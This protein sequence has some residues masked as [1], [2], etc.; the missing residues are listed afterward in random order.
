M[1]NIIAIAMG[2]GIGSLCRY[3]ITVGAEKI[4]PIYPLG[5]LVANLVGSLIIGIFWCYFD[6]I[7]ISHQFRLF[8]FTGFLGGF[9][10]F[11]TFSRECVQFF[12]AGEPMQALGYLLI[13]NAAGL[14]M[15]AL[16]FF[17]CHRFFRF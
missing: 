9:T 16:G 10:T 15:V 6:E 1:G 3:T 13:S 7:H 11:S 8:L 12:K 14:G 5:T 17:L 4:T 2:G